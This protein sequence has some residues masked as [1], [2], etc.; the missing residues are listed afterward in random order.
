MLLVRGATTTAGATAAW[1]IGRYTGTPRRAST[2]GLLAL[3]TTQLGQTL[4]LAGRDPLVITTALG[5]MLVLAAL[6]QTPFLSRLFGCRPVGPV[7]WSV[8][9][10]SATLAT[11]AAWLYERRRRRS[12]GPVGAAALSKPRVRRDASVTPPVSAESGADVAPT[13]VGSAGGRGPGPAA[14]SRDGRAPGLSL[15]LPPFGRPL[16]PGRPTAPG[17]KRTRLPG[18][19][20]NGGPGAGSGAVAGG[21]AVA[22]SG[23]T[24][25]AGPAAA[26][27][28]TAKPPPQRVASST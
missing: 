24:A 20:A 1:L 11:S 8:V 3:V 13:P 14:A 4:M 18:V 6:V 21:G 27:G 7:G 22:G 12:L 5:S 15:T 26:R 23:T 19:A 17:P 25:G 28:R 10:A 9:L 2:M 16:F